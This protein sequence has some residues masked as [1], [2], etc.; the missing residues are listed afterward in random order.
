M[1]KIK[2]L[3]VDDHAIFRDAV[4][5]LLD[6]H[7][8]I[9]IVGEASDGNESIQKALDFTP[10]VI[11]MDLVMPGMDGLEATRRIREKDPKVKVLALTQYEDREYVLSA[12][13]AGVTG[14]VVKRAMASEIVTAIRTAY[15]G[16]AYLH[17]SV[18]R[19]LI[20]GY[21]QLAEHKPFNQPT[22][23]Q[24]EIL[25]LVALGYTSRK[26][27]EMLQIGLKTV[28]GHRLKITKKLDLHNHTELIKYAVLTGLLSKDT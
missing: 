8:E 15:S 17:P 27:G 21:V 28:Q 4:R 14:Y 6:T 24:L 23:R 11:L 2:I 7:Y 12:F 13:K 19:A 16:D 22:A 1:G 20:E 25:R 9:D 3:I 26:I 5:A 18:A 10:D